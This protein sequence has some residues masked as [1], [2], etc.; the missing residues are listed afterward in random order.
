ML[1][2]SAVP[3]ADAALMSHFSGAP[4]PSPLADSGFESLTWTSAMGVTDVHSRIYGGRSSA[5]RRPSGDAPK[6]HRI[7]QAGA[8]AVSL[9]PDR[10][11]ASI[12]HSPRDAQ[13]ARCGGCGACV[14]WGRGMPWGGAGSIEKANEHKKT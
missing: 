5:G 1:G 7:Q 12:A 8:V 14:R 3:L 9:H 6:P 10:S 11:E 2:T 13:A 4:P